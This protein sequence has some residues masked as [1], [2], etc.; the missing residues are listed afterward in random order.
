M[1]IAT[2]FTLDNQ[3]SDSKILNIAGRQRMLSQKMTKEVL[4]INNF[5]DL[6]RVE[7]LKSL[8][9]TSSLFNKSLLALI[10]GNEDMGIS[11]VAD[12]NV[13]LQLKEVKKLWEPFYES[14]NII[15]NENANSEKYKKAL[16]YI[17][18]NNIPLLK[19]MNKAVTYYEKF[20][21]G[22]IA[23]LIN[24][25]YYSLGGTLFL[26]IFS[27]FFVRKTISNPL[28]ETVDAII[29]VTGGNYDIQVEV[30]SK[31]EIGKLRENINKMAAIIKEKINEANQKK[32]EAEKSAY[33]AKKVQEQIE[34]Q[35]NYL[36]ENTKKILNEMNKFAKG[37]LTVYVKPEREDDEIGRLFK[38]FN[39]A[40]SNIRNMIIK[41]TEVVE[42][43]ASASTQISSSS[44]E[45]AAGAQEQ[46]SQSAEI[47]AAVEQMTKTIMETAK[48]A[49][50]AA[51][52]SKNA[53]EIAKHG[54]SIIRDT[55]RGM[56]R[57]S[58][59]VEQAANTIKELGSSSEKIGTIIGVID[60]IA[61]QT[62]L[63]AL[64]AAI[65]AARAGEHGR[66]F[67]VVA[68]EVRKL[69]ERTTKATKE[70]GDMISQIQKDTGD[71]VEAMELGTSEVEKGMKLALESGKSLDEIIQSTT[72][73]IDIINQVAAAS[74]QESTTAEQISRSV[75]GINSVT[76]ETAMGIQQIAR[77]AEEL[78]NLTANLQNLVVQFSFNKKST[79]ELSTLNVRENGKIIIG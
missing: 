8:S 58:E 33:E 45:M 47:A 46:S 55:V 13:I 60:D 38:G 9:E 39:E 17:E 79:D 50:S 28:I 5:N 43:T 14:I 2:I 29:E 35:Q 70:I 24:T 42:A 68:D 74:E 32:E 34:R 11:A 49:N 61:D 78:N 59:V 41:V 21:S 26:G 66:G 23:S 20:A 44:E 3:K 72:N 31:D 4:A 19:K 40:V 51:E 10:E 57:I 52:Q 18:Q 53:G 69:A 64:N 30:N 65:E 56:E 54:G 48:H 76:Q 37:D 12:P 7:Y 75:E 63:L 27:F 67:A 25:L 36:A 77:A 15:I 22:K 6:R 71:A 62:N 1:V 16:N 73:V